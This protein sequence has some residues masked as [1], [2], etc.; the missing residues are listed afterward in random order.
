MSAPLLIWT[1]SLDDWAEDALLLNSQLQ[2]ETLEVVHLPAISTS[3]VPVSSLPKL[4]TPYTVVVTSSKVFDYAKRTPELWEVLVNSSEVITH[5]ATTHAKGRHLGLPMRHIAGIDKAEDL[6]EWIKSHYDQNHPFLIVRAR[7]TAFPMAEKLRTRGY[8][9][10][11]IICYETILSLKDSAGRDLTAKEI[12]EFTTHAQGY[13]TFFSPSAVESFA[14]VFTPKENRLF[15]SLVCI[16]IGPTT[17]THALGNF[18]TIKMADS[19]KLEDV[20]K[21]VKKELHEV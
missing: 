17:K 7:E 18:A 16:V 11:D 1:R 15:N 8:T 5:G 3:L 13:I 14:K 20:L 10:D 9:V 21:T 4:Q 6:T 12:K 19:A 2:G